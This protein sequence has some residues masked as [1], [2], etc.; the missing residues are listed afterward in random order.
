M[1]G[2][3]KA[4]AAVELQLV[5]ARRDEERARLAA[6]ERERRETEAAQQREAERVAAMERELAV[7]VAERNER[8]AP[9]F[10][11]LLDQLV[12]KSIA[13]VDH[14]LACAALER[15]VR[16]PT[17]QF[18]RIY[19]GIAAAIHWRFYSA[20]RN[21]KQLFPLKFELPTVGSRKPLAELLH[22]PVPIDDADEGEEG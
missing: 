10:D 1:P 15:P 16:S 20:T 9:E 4:L 14:G 21:G 8:L 18:T 11:V 7:M 5:A 3:A 12:A 19:Q 22:V 2:A 6:Q 13:L 17:P